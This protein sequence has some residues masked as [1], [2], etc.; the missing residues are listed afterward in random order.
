VFE[1]RVFE[2]R[3]FE[4][5]VFASKCSGS[6]LAPGPAPTAGIGRLFSASIS[7]SFSANN[8]P[9]AQNYPCG[10]VRIF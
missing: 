8:C 10:R 2:A 4:A 9:P 1:A 3:V 7:V 5:R 6:V